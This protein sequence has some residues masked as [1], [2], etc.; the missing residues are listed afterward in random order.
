MTAARQVLAMKSS[1]DERREGPT[2]EDE[3]RAFVHQFARVIRPASPPARR[4]DGGKGPRPYD[5][6]ELDHVRLPYGD[7][8]QD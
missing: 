5:P 3:L 1:D 6:N 2:V 7:D 8:D 4:P